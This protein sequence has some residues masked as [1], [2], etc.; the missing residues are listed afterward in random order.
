[1]DETSIKRAE[2]NLNRGVHVADNNDTHVE[3]HNIND[4]ALAALIQ[5]FDDAPQ[6]ES[7]YKHLD[8][9]MMKVFG[10][11]DV[12]DFDADERMGSKWVYIE[13]ANF[14][15]NDCF[16]RLVSAWDPPLKAVRLLFIHL[17]KFDKDLI[18][19][20]RHD[21]GGRDWGW[22][23]LSPKG[24]SYRMVSEQRELSD[25]AE[26]LAADDEEFAAMDLFDEGYDD[27]LSDNFYEYFHDYVDTK[28]RNEITS[29]RG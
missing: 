4:E 2:F 20:L 8:Y 17:L 25:I 12:E 3:F 23:V 11:T 7:G 21:N 16:V 14:E 27:Y 15:K 29:I 19:S 24:R 9:V 5:L 10:L 26:M 28:I 1:M 6:Y 18:V 22:M 13:D